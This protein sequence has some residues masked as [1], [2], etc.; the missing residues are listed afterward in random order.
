MLNGLKSMDCYIFYIIT[1]CI[2]NHYTEFEIDRKIVLPELTGHA[3]LDGQIQVGRI[4]NNESSVATQLQT[5]ALNCVGTLS[6]QD[7]SNLNKNHS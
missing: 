2:R 3:A 7:L 6:V 4:E 1:N 5:K